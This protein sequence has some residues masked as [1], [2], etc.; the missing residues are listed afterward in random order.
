MKF[1]ACSLKP[2]AQPPL[3][4][5]PQCSPLMQAFF[6]ALLPQSIHMLKFFS[7]AGLHLPMGGGGVQLLEAPSPY[8]VDIRGHNMYRLC[9]EHIQGHRFCPQLPSLPFCT[10]PGDNLLTDCYKSGPPLP[11]KS[12]GHLLAECLNYPC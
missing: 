10:S 6:S 5:P 3:S 9:V 1:P 4:E 11:P 12:R 7:H 2:H 8:A